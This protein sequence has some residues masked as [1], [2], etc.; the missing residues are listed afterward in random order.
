MNMAK[1]ELVYTVPVLIVVD[2]DE[3]AIESVNIEIESL[4][5]PDGVDDKALEI[6]ESEAWP[7]WEMGS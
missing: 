3:K 4:A 2:L 5:K 6:A 7:I 1:V